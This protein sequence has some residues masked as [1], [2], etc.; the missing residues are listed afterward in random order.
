MILFKFIL[1]PAYAETK[2]GYKDMNALAIV[3][4]EL[5]FRPLDPATDSFFGPWNIVK[6]VGEGIDPPIYKVPVKATADAIKTVFGDK[7]LGQFVTGNFAFA[8][9]MRQV[10]NLA[11]K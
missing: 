1:D 8:R 5:M 7:T 2:K 6:Y 10:A 4:N 3:M 9:I 11:A